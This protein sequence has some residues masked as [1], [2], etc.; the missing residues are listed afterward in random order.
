[1]SFLSNNVIYDPSNLDFCEVENPAAAE[2]TISAV[3]KEFKMN[4]LVDKS[5]FQT[6]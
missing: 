4:K 6:P 2:K 3:L 5:E 1:M